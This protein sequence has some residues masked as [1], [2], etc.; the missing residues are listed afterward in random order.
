MKV[1]H[2]SALIYIFIATSGAYAGQLFETMPTT[3]NPDDK[4]VFYSH[5]FIVEGDNQKP[6]N[7]RWGEYDFPAIKQSLSDDQYNLIAYHRAK[8]TNPHQFAVRLASDIKTLVSKGV[9]FNNITLVGFSRGGAISILT[10]NLLASDKLNIIILAGC[11]AFVSKNQQVSVF[12]N[13][14]SIYETSDGV[15]SCQ[16]LINRSKKVTSFQE[17]AI[18]TGKEHGAFYTP[19]STWVTPVKAWINASGIKNE[20]VK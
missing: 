1:G 11:G 3:I 9:P 19:I 8:N 20:Q 14:H 10:S 17:I 2:L 16:H 15:G 12:G 4:Y 6:V 13:V 7:P 5:G 18:S